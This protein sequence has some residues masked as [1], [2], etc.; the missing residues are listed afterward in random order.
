MLM[1]VLKLELRVFWMGKHTLFPF[2]FG[3]LMKWLGGIPSTA[4]LPITWS[5]KP[6]ANMRK[7]MNWLC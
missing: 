6:S 1:V 2:P 5:A 4:P 3:W 7:T